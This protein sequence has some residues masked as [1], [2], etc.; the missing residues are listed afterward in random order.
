[1]F[2]FYPSF[3]PVC[4]LGSLALQSSHVNAY[5]IVFVPFQ[6]KN[7]CRGHVLKCDCKK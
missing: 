7:R 1:M 4:T 3:S 2:F 6:I 5:N